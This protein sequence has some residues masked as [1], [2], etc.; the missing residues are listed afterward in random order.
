MRLH[1]NDRTIT[2]PLEEA[3]HSIP[4]I[5]SDDSLEVFARGVKEKEPIAC[6]ATLI[7]TSWGHSIPLISSKGVPLLSLLLTHSKYD[8]LC[9]ALHHILPLFLDCSDSLTSNEKFQQLFMSLI[10]ADRGY[11]KMA[12]NL[13]LTDTPGPVLRQVAIMIE[14]QFAAYG[15]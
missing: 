9:E 5:E 14:S 1:L 3:L 2:I 12:K 15:R 10:T 8:A 11:V 6:F 13:L 7:A 4:D